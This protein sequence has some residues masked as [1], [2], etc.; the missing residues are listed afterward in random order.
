MKNLLPHLAETSKQ[1]LEIIRVRTANFFLRLKSFLVSKK[2]R[3]CVLV[4]GMTLFAFA[5]FQTAH[6]ASAKGYHEKWDA[7]PYRVDQFLIQGKSIV[8]TM[9]QTV[10][11]NVE[12]VPGT[13]TL[14]TNIE[15]VP[16]T[17]ILSNISI[18]SMFKTNFVTNNVG[19]M[20]LGPYAELKPGDYLIRLKYRCKK[21]L[22]AVSFFPDRTA[23]PR[24]LNRLPDNG[25]GWY[26]YAFRVVPG[27]AGFTPALL[28]EYMGAGLVALEAVEIETNHFAGG[29]MI[30]ITLETLLGLILLIAWKN[31]NQRSPLISFIVAFLRRNI[32][33]RID[34]YFYKELIPNYIFGLVFF[35][36]LLMSNELFY[37]AGYYIQYNIPFR[38][39]LALLLNMIPFLLSYSIPF[40]VLPA[41]LLTMG[42]LS[43]DSEIV[44]MKTCGI[45]AI[46]IIRPGILFGIVLALL[47]IV[48]N[49]SVVAPSNLTYLTLR[50]KMVAQKPA[51]ELKEKAF[52]EVGGFKLSFDRVRTEKNVEVMYNIHVV[53]ING[54]KTIEGEKGRLYSDPENPEHYV[55]KFMNGTMSEVTKSKK[56]SD[57]EEE[58]FFVVSFKY[59]SINTYFNL[60]DESVFQSPDTMTYKDLQSEVLTLSR[61]STRHIESYLNEKT[62]L[63]KDIDNLYRQYSKIAGKLPKEEL[64]QQKVKLENMA[65]ELRKKIRTINQDISDNQKSLPIFQMQKLNEKLALP[66]ASFVF[67]LISLSLGMYTARS[68]RGEGLG[69]SIIIMLSYYGLKY[70]INNLIF[71]YI[72]PPWTEWVPNMLFFTIGMVLL[73]RKMRE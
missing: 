32:F 19:K 4:L 36:V 51:V 64:R 71:K 26:T 24:K 57:T 43:Q 22:T 15:L 58:S 29:R 55:M 66:F 7:A 17:N 28:V 9:K 13:N 52:V 10:F 73:I 59:M 67:A 12:T 56:D 60:G 42:R 40:A 27:G 16:F 63:K 14:T 6:Y 41:Y 62:Q 11:T 61:D 68:G 35:T 45:S 31:W 48:F 39:V 70:G 69:I 18:F 46:R 53:D 50:A 33:S 1:I 54:R 23:A 30:L 37:L 2:M 8:S 65:G 3:L 5:A 49:D 34:R 21:A 44:A 47:A 25:I 38:Q 72:L 20:F